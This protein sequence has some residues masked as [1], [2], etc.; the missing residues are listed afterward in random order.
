M[1]VSV[2]TLAIKGDLM[3][4][5]VQR[6]AENAA[7]ESVAAGPPTSNRVFDMASRAV[8]L[9]GAFLMLGVGCAGTDLAAD[10][11]QEQVAD[12]DVAGDV[13]GIADG[14][15][16]DQLEQ[17]AWLDDAEKPKEDS[18][19]V[20]VQGCDP[21]YVCIYPQNAGWNG[22]R[23]SHRYLRYGCYNLSN[24]F[25]I[26]R[27]FNNQTGGVP[28]RTCLDYN[29]GRCE[30]YLFPPGWNPLHPDGWI[31]KNFTPVN[32]IILVRP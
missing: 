32:S 15:G 3:K 28:M 29:C 8:V 6:F 24:M 20:A 2:A 25:G 18:P 12:R 27:L 10:E 4:R 14:I 17:A 1:A 30:G 16:E 11:E 5:T 22:G 31:D 21:G 7:I 26:H 9:V 13:D 23:P 19:G